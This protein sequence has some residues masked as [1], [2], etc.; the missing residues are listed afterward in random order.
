MKTIMQWLRLHPLKAVLFTTIFTAIAT[1]AGFREDLQSLFIAAFIVNLVLWAVTFRLDMLAHEKLFRH[2]NWMRMNKLMA[3]LLAGLFSYTPAQSA[4]RPQQQESVAAIGVGVVVICVGGYCVY[5]V[6]KVCQKKFPPKSAETN[7]NDSFSAAGDEYGGATEYSSIGSCYVPSLNSFPYEDLLQNPTTFTLSVALRQGTAQMKMSANNEEGT[8]QTWD[9]F[10][11][12]IADHG[13]FLTGRPALEPQYERD[14]IPC[15]RASVPLSFDPFT[16][17]V[18]HNT[19]GE[20]RHVTIERSPNLQDWY[21][22][23]VT[24]VSDNTG[25]QVVDTTREGQMFYRVSLQ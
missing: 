4:E 9:Q 15:D 22:L 2:E 21:P 6:V 10:V 1:A 7:S 24:D 20:L 19:G 3:L 8:T 25:F 14:R 13:L 12:D 11:S 17:R 23:L 18:T 5:R 16:G